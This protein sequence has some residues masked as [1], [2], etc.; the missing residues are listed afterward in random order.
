MFYHFHHDNAG[1]FNTPD[2]YYS[3]SNIGNTNNV[4]YAVSG[5]TRKLFFHDLD[6]FFQYLGLF[7]L[8]T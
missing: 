5:I 8:Q 1:A 2:S 6:M 3:D 4:E 7:I